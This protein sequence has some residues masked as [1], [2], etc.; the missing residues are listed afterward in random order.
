MKESEPS[1]AM[2]LNIQVILPIREGKCSTNCIWGFITFA[3]FD[4]QIK[5]F[6]EN[7]QQLDWPFPA[8]QSL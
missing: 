4:E 2:S 6:D 7:K 8:A 1:F 3:I 5:T